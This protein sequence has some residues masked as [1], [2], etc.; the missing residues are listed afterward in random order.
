MILWSNLIHFRSSNSVCYSFQ[1]RFPWGFLSLSSM[2]SIDTHSIRNKIQILIRLILIIRSDPS[3]FDYLVW[4][5][6]SIS[7]SFPSIRL[8]I[9]GFR[10]IRS[11]NS[12]RNSIVT[13]SREPTHSEKL[14]GSTGTS[15]I[16]SN[17]S[18]SR[19]LREVGQQENLHPHSWNSSLFSYVKILSSLVPN[20]I[21]NSNLV[22]MVVEWILPPSI[23]PHLWIRTMIRHLIF[24]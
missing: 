19:I 13:V 24:V 4:L 11:S 22:P 1:T 3:R 14:P 15:T 21:L 2:S 6:I 23:S 20:N 7:L 8:P 17:L 5:K 12:Q 9:G 16:S 18:D 10:P